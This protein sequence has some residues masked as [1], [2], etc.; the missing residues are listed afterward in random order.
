MIT[1]VIKELFTN[2]IG[3]EVEFMAMPLAL[4]TVLLLIFGLFT[5]FANGTTKRLF[6]IGII[7]VVITFCVFSMASQMGFV[8]LPLTLGGV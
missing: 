8:T 5:L 7:I 1:T 2:L 4:L 6:L 3:S